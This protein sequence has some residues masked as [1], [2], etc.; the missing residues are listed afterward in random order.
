MER[1]AEG[2]WERGEGRNSGGV[3]WGIGVKGDRERG[4]GGE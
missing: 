4:G 1:L 3:K 2:N